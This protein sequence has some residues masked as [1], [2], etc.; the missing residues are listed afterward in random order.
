MHWLGKPWAPQSLLN[1]WP[2]FDPQG[3]GGYQ[4]TAATVRSGQ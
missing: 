1:E 2:L 4:L 3:P